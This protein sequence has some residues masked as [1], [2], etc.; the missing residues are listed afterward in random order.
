MKIFSFVPA[1]AALITAVA[2]LALP[3]D[4]SCGEMGCDALQA[5][6]KRNFLEHPARAYRGLTN[7]ELLRRGLPLKYPVLR[8]GTPTRR[9]GP[10]ALPQSD[11]DT[12][13]PASEKTAYTGIIQIRN[14]D[15]DNVLG[16][17]SAAPLNS[18]IALQST[19]NGALIVNFEADPTG[20]ST[21]LNLGMENS[22]TGYPYLGLV[23]A[24]ADPDSVFGPT[25]PNFGFIAG[26]IETASGAIPANIDNSYSAHYGKQRTG[27]SGVWAFD[28]STDVLTPQWVNPDG[29]TPALDTYS[30]GG[31]L[32]FAGN[33]ATAQDEFGPTIVPITFKLIPS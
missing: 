26:T 32:I 15:T 21:Q 6:H 4:V 16:Y 20:P 29:S 25:L 9:T 18:I 10:S 12:S 2:G 23:Q 24:I 11:P 8:R 27:E 1:F 14:A 30:L 19:S 3:V 7:A 5:A 33:R 31:E 13:P 22:G 17:V 28:P